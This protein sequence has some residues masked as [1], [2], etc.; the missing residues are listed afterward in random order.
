MTAH[1]VLPTWFVNTLVLRMPLAGDPTFLELARRVRDVSVA[2]QA[3]GLPFDRLVEELQPE[4]EIGVTPLFQAVFSYLSDAAPPL[5]MS[6]LTASLLDPKPRVAKFDLTLSLH[7]WE[8]R[9]RGWLTCRAG[10]F[11]PA[12]A[13]RM[14]RHLRTLLEGAAAD[15]G[16]RLSG[17]PLLSE[18]ERGQL[19]TWA[20]EP[21]PGL[22][23]CVHHLFEERARSA[24]D[25]PA[26]ILE[27]ETVSYAELDA[28]AN[29]LARHLLAL[30]LRT[31]G[32]G[33]R[34]P[35]ALGRAGHGDA[36][37]P[38]GRRR[39]AAARSELPAGAHAGDPGGLGSPGG[40]EHRGAGL[41]PGVPLGG[42]PVLLDRDAGAIAG[43][44]PEPVRTAAGP[45]PWPT[46]STPR[47]PPA[48]PRAWASPTARS[49][50]TWTRSAAP[51]GSAPGT[52]CSSSPRRASTSRWSRC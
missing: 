25:A 30:G 14:T 8:G 43:R 6:G 45:R 52:A 13:E 48:G 19:R 40:G 16:Q 36:G 7:E 38:Q 34:L 20:G 44:S 12:T 18:A 47:A 2:A 28:R 9:L 31:G 15:P 24:P 42:P 26:L 17:L 49:R 41:A 37:G 23:T 50:P 3:H 51:T 11:E 4:R 27:T 22:E 46:S 1:G 29:R 33:R 10:L 5:R 21:L 35:G 39:L 32:P